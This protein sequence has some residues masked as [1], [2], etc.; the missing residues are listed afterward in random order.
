MAHRSAT[1]GPKGNKCKIRSKGAMRGLRD[2]V[3]ESWDPRHISRTI[4]ARNF[5]FS[6]EIGHWGT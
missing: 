1:G 2:L 6:T 3:L 4:E 5:K